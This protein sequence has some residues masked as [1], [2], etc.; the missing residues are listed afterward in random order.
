MSG[1]Q[2]LEVPEAD[3]GARIDRWFRRLFPHVPHGK[4]EKLL[5]TG[6]VRVDG[7]RV[8]SSHRLE[9]GQQVRIPPLPDPSAP[10]PKTK[11]QAVQLRD[12]AIHEDD[13]LI[14]IDKPFGLAVQ[15]GTKTTRH[16]DGMLPDGWRLVHRLDRDTT[17]VLVVAKS[18]SAA[19]WA[20]RAFQSK[21]AVK[22]YWA[23]T[24][25]VPKPTAGE[26]KGYLAKGRRGLEFGRKLEGQEI[27]VAARHGEAGA[28][29]AH[30]L[31]SC[32]QVAGSVAAF[33]VMRPLTG[34]THQLRVHAQLLG[35]PIA[36]DPKYLTDRP[37]PRSLQNKLHLHARELVL[38]RPDGNALALTAPLPAHMTL[39]FERLGF[40]EQVEP[41]DWDA[42]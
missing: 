17:G 26:I 13:D 3:A 1:V 15:G 39:A 5:R 22:T 8:K 31:Y 14:A 30:T 20:A 10:R 36:G 7:G 29:H 6:Q 16:I 11:A 18:A 28:K 41:I 4:V 25:G 38:P 21:R 34:R 35:A 32:A 42:L 27:M 40:S 24:N 33:V 2:V 19:A 12:W 37:L 23:V 9:A